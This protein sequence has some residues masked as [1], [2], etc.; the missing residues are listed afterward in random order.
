[1]RISLL[2][3]LVILAC[4]FPAAAQDKAK[5]NALTPKEIAD[6]WILLFDDKTTVGWTGDNGPPK[7]GRT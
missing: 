1:M 3:T 4:T 7:V 6:G 5:P 2:S